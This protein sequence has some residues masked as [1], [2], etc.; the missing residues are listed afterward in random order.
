MKIVYLL[1]NLVL[2]FI[3]HGCTNTPSDQTLKIALSKSIATYPIELSETFGYYN[4]ANIALLETKKSKETIQ[5]YRDG[6]ADA[7]VV[8]LDQAID[9]YAQ[10]NDFVIVMVLNRLHKVAVESENDTFTV[11]I[12]RRSYLMQHSQQIKELIG[13][14]YASLGYMQVNINMVIRTRSKYIGVSEAQ[15]RVTL[16]Q[17]DFGDANQNYLYLLS[18]TPLLLRYAL[19]IEKLKGQNE[20]LSIKDAFLPKNT[21]QDLHRYKKWTYKIGRH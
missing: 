7:A 19:N 15:L 3:F 11:L 12:I 20:D 13:G 10:Q 5:A 6:L 8:S 4:S 17:L 9:L 14:W 18:D 16:S 21:I 1:I 2:A